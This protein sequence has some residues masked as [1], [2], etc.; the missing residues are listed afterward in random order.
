M[1]GSR[2]NDMAHKMPVS[3]RRFWLER[4]YPIKAAQ[5]AGVDDGGG[6]ILERLTD[7]SNPELERL[8][9]FGAIWSWWH[10]PA[11]EREQ[12]WALD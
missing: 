3:Y 1:T 12:W 5:L 9:R 8:R 2:T 11:E 7:R 6:G 4:V 10:V